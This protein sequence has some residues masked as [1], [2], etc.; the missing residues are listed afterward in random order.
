MAPSPACFTIDRR[1]RDFSVRTG[2]VSAALAGAAATGTVIGKP[3]DHCY[4][5]SDTNELS[6]LLPRHWSC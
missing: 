5:L 6:I 4:H 2:P 1:W 3:D